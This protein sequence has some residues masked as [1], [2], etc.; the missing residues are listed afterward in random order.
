MNPKSETVVRPAAPTFEEG[1]VFAKFLDQ[2]ADG[3][4]SFMLGAKFAELIAGTFTTPA[5]DFSFKNVLF[6]ERDN[7]IV[8]AVSGYTADQHNNCSDEVLTK[9]MGFPVIRM[10]MLQLAFG[11][12]WR[13]LNTVRSGDFYLQSIAVHLECRGAGIGSLLL[14]AMEDRAAETTA[15]RIVLDVAEDNER[16]RR[17]YER[18]GMIVGTRWPRHLPIPQIRV[19]RMVKPLL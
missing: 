14:D 12:L 13:F 6:A 4:I 7:L 19:L 18:R 17:L 15:E 16:A 10:L 11:S 5:H 2:A 3:F 8:G 1:L 9:A